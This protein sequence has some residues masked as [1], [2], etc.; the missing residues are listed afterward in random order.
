MKYIKYQ[1]ACGETVF[2]KKFAWSE[3]AEAIAKAE[4]INGEYTI[5]DDGKPEET[6]NQ[7]TDIDARIAALEEQLAAAKI[8]LGVE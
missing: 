7:P 8:L 6:P 3:E 1:Y 4:A 5:E 2:E